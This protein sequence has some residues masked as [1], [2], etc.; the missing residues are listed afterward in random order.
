MSIGY[1]WQRL[2]TAVGSLVSDGALKER[3]AGAAVNLIGLKPEDFPD[4]DNLRERFS[5]LM[6]KLDEMIAV[7]RETPRSLDEIEAESRRIADEGPDLA[8]EILSIFNDVA[9]RDP[10]HHYHVVSDIDLVKHFAE[11]QTATPLTLNPYDFDRLTE[12]EL[13][14]LKALLDKA[15]R[16]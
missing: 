6:D 15:R 7:N 12:D 4:E 2:Y 11:T 14:Q 16:A 9:L 8:E 5:D 13:S 10:N 1:A 3:L